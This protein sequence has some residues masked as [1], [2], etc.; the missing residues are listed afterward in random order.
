MSEVFQSQS[1]AWRDRLNALKNVPPV[2]RLIW[3]SSRAQSFGAIGTR[4]LNALVP[5][6]TLWVGKLIIDSVVGTL[7]NHS[8]FPQQ[9]WLYLALEFAFTAASAILGRASD[10]CDARLADQFVREVSLRI[11]RHAASLDLTSFED[12]VF[13]DKLERARVQATD[14]IGMLH[15]M[16]SLIQQVV[17]LV[18]LSIA[19]IVFSPLLFLVLVVCVIPAFLGESHFAFLGYSL[20]YS[21]TPLRRELDY[22]RDLGTKRESAKELKVFG[23]G[24]YLQKRFD[25]IQGEVIDRNRK[26]LRKRLAVGALLGILSSAGYY[27][28]YAYIVFR[29]LS[30]H[31]TVG[32][33]TL[34]AGALAGCSSQIQQLFSTFT[35]IADQA[36]FL[37]DLMQFFA[38][39]PK[40]RS[41]E[42]TVPAP[43][44]IREGFE[45]R[46][47]CFKYPGSDR[48]V[49]DNLDFRMHPG[50][51][52]ALVGANGQG[53]TTFVKL[54]SRLY[55]PT[56]GQI[57]LDGADLRDYAIE[58]LQK[59]IGVIFQDFVRY[60]MT[61]RE[62][63]GV[64]R[65]ESIQDTERLL[66]AAGKSKA[67]ELIE[68]FPDGMEQM[69]G[70]RFEGGLDLSGGEWQK[71]A[72]SRA[73]MR[74]AQVVILDEPTSALDAMAEYEVFCRFAELTQGRMAILISHRFSTV[75]MTDR[76]VVLENGAIHEQGTHQ[77]LVAQGGQYARMFELQAANYR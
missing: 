54:L 75:R 24:S 17:T 67:S 38:V 15:A 6:G 2:L 56:S 60:D 36:L 27:G 3:Q 77:Q 20:A 64:G 66:M 16:G 44:P 72:L 12:P 7:K 55:E 10:Y 8:P 52:I 76:I 70:R 50:E 31:L 63:I 14:R 57:L 69:L 30:G 1:K 11:M 42:Q 19:V 49:L 26:L 28:S 39:Q 48:P 59:E 51:R 43:R 61:A 34:L 68:R 58:D 62:N 47:V 5:F 53:K 73:Y 40:I 45:F 71:F 21:L 33:L 32:D 35:G 18:S 9:I 13:Y 74:D 22:L 29:T 46:K 23:L 37:S 4:V 65:I 25:S 41:K